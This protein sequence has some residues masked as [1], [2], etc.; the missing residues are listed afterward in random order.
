MKKK[1]CHIYHDR[2]ISMVSILPEHEAV[3]LCQ[4]RI[5]TAVWCRASLLGILIWHNC[6]NNISPKIEP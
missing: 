5:F 1:G 3:L 2:N 6:Y 4:L